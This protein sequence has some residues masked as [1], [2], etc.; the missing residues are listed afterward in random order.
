MRAQGQPRVTRRRVPECALLGPS[1]ADQVGHEADQRAAGEEAHTDALPPTGVGQVAGM[2]S[3]LLAVQVHGDFSV[4]RC[5]T[6]A[7]TQ[8]A[9]GD[10]PR[11]QSGHLL[12]ELSST[13]SIGPDAADD[14]AEACQFE[15]RRGDVEDGSEHH[16]VVEEATDAVRH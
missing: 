14:Q 16:H 2:K 7:G 11:L 13:S 9:F 5:A 4:E 6:E 10:I 1:E 3:Y 12:T 15:E 8:H